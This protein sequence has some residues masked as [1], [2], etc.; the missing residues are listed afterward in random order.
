MTEH[1]LLLPGL[2]P[3]TDKQVRVAFEGGLQSSDGGVLLLRKVDGK[4]GLADRLAAVIPDWRDPGSISHGIADML[5]FR[6][7][8]IAAG[9][10]DADDCDALRADPVFKLTVRRGPETGDALC[11][12]P[13]MS[14]LENRVSRRTLMRL[15][16]ALER[17]LARLRDFGLG[18]MVLTF[19]LDAH[20]ARPLAGRPTC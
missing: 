20:E 18:A 5:R 3:V 9:Y 12:Q 17:A 1:T 16:A 7:F 8:S 10:E 13:T 2:S 4:L 11:S 19:G 14:R 15:Q 6:I